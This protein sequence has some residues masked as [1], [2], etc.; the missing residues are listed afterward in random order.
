M[1]LLT[2]QVF[3]FQLENKQTGRQGLENTAVLR[4]CN[5]GIA[6]KVA[7]QGFVA[8]LGNGS[9]CCGARTLRHESLF[10][11]SPRQRSADRCKRAAP[12]RGFLV[13]AFSCGLRAGISHSRRHL[14]HLVSPCYFV[15]YSRTRRGSPGCLLCPRTVALKRS[16]NNTRLHPQTPIL[17]SHSPFNIS[18]QGVLFRCFSLRAR[19][20]C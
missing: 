15:S 18:N 6:L 16:T 10:E 19:V 1:S 9:S 11:I 14:Q 3:V 5:A 4:A 7:A 17:S 2:H 13:C 8:A 20:L 12:L